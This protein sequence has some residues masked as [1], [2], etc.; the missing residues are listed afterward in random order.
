MVTESTA[1]VALMAAIG[2]PEKFYVCTRH[3]AGYWLADRIAATHNQAWQTCSVAQG[4][5]TAVEL[6]GH[7]IRLFKS[8][9]SMNISGR[10]IARLAQYYGIAA[11]RI[12]VAHDELAFEPGVVRM[13]FSGGAAGHN[14]IRSIVDSLGDADFWRCRIG[15]GHPGMAA[16]VKSYVLHKPDDEDKTSIDRALEHMC[17]HFE[18]FALGPGRERALTAIHSYSAPA[19]S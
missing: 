6:A 19:L 5:T 11:N 3:S 16:A 4:H 14:G 17:T 15:I 10:V 13:K 12:L 1:P 2:N 8:G 18:L 9:V 7:K